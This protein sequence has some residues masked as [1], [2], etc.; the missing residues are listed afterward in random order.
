MSRQ[1]CVVV[2]TVCTAEGALRIIAQEILDGVLLDVQLRDG[3]GMQ[4]ATALL[5][6]NI[7]FVIVTAYDRQTLPS[8]LKKAPFI[9]KP[10]IEGELVEV[11]RRAFRPSLQTT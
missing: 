7:P 2:G 1:G 8:V 10:M 4:I 3:S 11:A 5:E 6:G 9:S